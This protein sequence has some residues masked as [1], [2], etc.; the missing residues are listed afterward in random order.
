MRCRCSCTS[1]WS[2]V[3]MSRSV[4]QTVE[5]E[6]LKTWLGGSVEVLTNLS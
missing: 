6:T 1:L 4:V 5:P 3:R 2:T